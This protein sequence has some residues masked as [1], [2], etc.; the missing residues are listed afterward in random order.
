MRIA[1]S[2]QGKNMTGLA[3]QRFVKE[4]KTICQEEIGLDLGAQGQ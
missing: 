2:S 1:V 4:G 3:D